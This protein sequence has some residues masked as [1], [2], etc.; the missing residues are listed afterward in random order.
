MGLQ[1]PRVTGAAYFALVDEFV[2]AVMSRWPDAVLQF[3]D[4]STEHALALLERYRHH[5]LVFNDDIQG[6]AATALGGLYGAMRVLGLDNAALAAQRVLCVGAG[7][8]GMGVV[9]MVAQGMEKQGL[10]HGAACANF[11]V[12]DRDGLVT[13]ARRGLPPHVQPFARGGDEAGRFEGEPLLDTIRRVRPTVLLG[14]AGA[15]RLFT[16]E[17][18]RLMNDVNPN[19]RPVIFPMSNPISRMECTSEE[20]VAATGGRAVFASGSPQPP[21][22]LGGRT[23]KVAQ[24]RTRQR[25][26]FEMMSP[27]HAELRKSTM[28]VEHGVQRCLL[29]PRKGLGVHSRPWFDA[30]LRLPVSPNNP[31][32]PTA[33]QP[34]NVPNR[35]TTC[36]YSRAWRWARGWARHASSPTTC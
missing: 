11:W 12:T 33:N 17:V 6:T 20:A 19:Q 27:N 16:P 4:F 13:S 32:Q 26:G 23:V 18:L 14:L 29:M 2:Q 9:R 22:T 35:R 25:A 8:A 28:G 24:V 21:V 5:H 30:A 10:T 36:T 7:S 15:G 34:T 3:E 1:Q 31:N